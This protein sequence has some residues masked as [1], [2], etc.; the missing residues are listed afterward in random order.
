MVVNYHKIIKAFKKSMNKALM[1]LKNKK[2]CLIIRHLF[3]NPNYKHKLNYRYFY[4]YK[5]F[6]NKSNHIIINIKI[7]NNNK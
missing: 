6:N 5:R 7:H 4:F 2:F 1:L 3:N